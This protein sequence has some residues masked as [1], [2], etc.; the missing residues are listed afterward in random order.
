MM[1][2]CFIY[3][4][5]GV[6][7]VRRACSTTEPATFITTFQPCFVRSSVRSHEPTVMISDEPMVKLYV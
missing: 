2:F 4:V 6:T 1:F 3:V 7:V 5:V